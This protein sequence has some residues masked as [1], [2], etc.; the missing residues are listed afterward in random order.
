MKKKPF[1][2][3]GECYSADRSG[4][5]SLRSR[6]EFEQLSGPGSGGF[7]VVGRREYLPREEQ[8]RQDRERM[9]RAEREMNARP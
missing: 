2:F 4:N 7:R 3:T 8:L 5:F 1:R 9:E 6:A